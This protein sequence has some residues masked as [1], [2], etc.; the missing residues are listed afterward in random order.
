MALQYTG[1]VQGSRLA[2]AEY[3]AALLP[4]TDYVKPECATMNSKS[5]HFRCTAYPKISIT[6]KFT[7]DLNMRA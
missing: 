2:K 3:R 1:E 7:Y 4:M 6:S 5:P